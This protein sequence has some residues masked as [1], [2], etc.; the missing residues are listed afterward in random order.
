MNTVL[1]KHFGHMNI[2]LNPGGSAE[3]KFTFS[4]TGG[5]RPKHP[6]SQVVELAAERIRV[7]GLPCAPVACLSLD[8]LPPCRRN[9]KLVDEQPKIPLRPSDTALPPEFSGRE[10]CQ[11]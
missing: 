5:K 7:G 10:S 2:L 9:A 3:T 1:Q 11:H 6:R 4:G 8:T